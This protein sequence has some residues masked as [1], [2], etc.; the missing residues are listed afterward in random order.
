VPEK[1]HSKA[2]EEPIYEEKAF[3]EVKADCI[4]LSRTGQMFFVLQTLDQVV[5]WEIIDGKPFHTPNNVPID[6]NE[7]V[8][9]L[10]DKGWNYHNLDDD[11]MK[12]FLKPSEED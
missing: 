9:V 4:I 5:Y 6:P 8:K 12:K 7:K 10:T 2:V 11:M 1:N 3:K